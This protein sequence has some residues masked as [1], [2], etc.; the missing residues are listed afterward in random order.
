MNRQG[1]PAGSGFDPIDAVIPPADEIEAAIKPSD[2]G[3]TWKER[4]ADA[5]SAEQRPLNEAAGESEAQASAVEAASLRVR[6]KSAKA[7]LQSAD[8]TAKRTMRA[9][10]RAYLWLDLYV[11]RPS[12]A[13]VVYWSRLTGLVLGDMA[14][15]SGAILLLGETPFNAFGQASSAAISAVTLGAIGSTTKRQQ[16]TRSF[17]KVFTG[18]H[19]IP[20]RYKPLF[21]GRN[22]GDRVARNVTLLAFLGLALIAI[23]IFSL[24][25][26]TEGSAAAWTF[27]LLSAAIGLASFVNS[28]STTCV[29][30]EYLDRLKVRVDRAQAWLNECQHDSVFVLHDGAVAKVK[31]VQAIWSARGLAAWWARQREKFAILNANPRAV[32]NGEG[33][34]QPGASVNDEVGHD[35]GSEDAA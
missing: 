23:A 21:L 31:S 4:E 1:E 30:G 15:C 20:S 18:D 24:R 22:E 16:Q 11:D 29:F 17:A 7:R 25:D 5:A 28:Y 8:R 19:K 9:Y 6:R 32:G 14:A 27:G 13:K 33:A 35:M 34:K 2:L 3:E 26:T 10:E 12:H